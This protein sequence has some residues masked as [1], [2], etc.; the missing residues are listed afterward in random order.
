MP[1]Y[2]YKFYAK[3]PFRLCESRTTLK[4]NCQALL[5]KILNIEGSPNGGKN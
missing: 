3:T 5:F 4:I 1:R 2:T